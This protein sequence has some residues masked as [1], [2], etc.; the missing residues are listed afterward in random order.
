MLN[1]TQEK[2]VLEQLFHQGYITRN[3]CL[4]NYITRL[5]AIICN[6]KKKGYEFEEGVYL[7]DGLGHKDYIYKLK[8]KPLDL[9]FKPRSYKDMAIEQI[10]EL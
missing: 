7:S 8:G 4:K 3:T 1:K 10:N 9:I 6:L 2:W 5:G